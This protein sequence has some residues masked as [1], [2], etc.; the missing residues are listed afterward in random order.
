V[1]R[2]VV[3]GGG[4]IGCAVAERLSRERGRHRVTLLERD[5]VGAHASGAAAGM[6]VSAGGPSLAARSREL[7]PEL[8]ERVERAS[9][10]AVEFQEVE[11]ISPAL[12]AAEER[13]LR[14]GPGRWLDAAEA[15]RAEP[16]LGPNVRGA[17]VRPEA[18]VTP[19]RLVEALARTALAQGADL[20]EG[21]PVSRL[22]VRAGR[23]QGVQGPDGIVPA[24]LVVVA[25][26]P[27]SASLTSPVGV[28][29]DVRP[30]RGQ[31]VTL[32]PRAAPLGRMLTWRGSYLVPKPDGSV[33]AGSTEEEVGFDARP[34]AE[35]VHGL[36]EFATRA[37]PGLGNAAVERVWAAL[38]PA[39]PDGLPVIG[40]APGLP[41]LVLAAGHNRDG[42]LLAPA[43]AELVAETVEG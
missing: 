41:N 40:A 14:R 9:A 43:T 31:L 32:R 19:P 22:V 15:L 12:T 42:I 26:G 2:I 39:T 25:A 35:G 21:V 8:V 20:R 10:I 13:L 18:Q 6:L 17:A 16:G 28:A 27:W 7:F 11:A 5:R 3:V 36:L 23:L 4:V 29:L 33:V 34:T 24:D 37:V 1:T 30:S 38:R